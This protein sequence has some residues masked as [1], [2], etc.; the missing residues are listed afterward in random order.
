MSTH[1]AAISRLVPYDA[2]LSIFPV[3]HPQRVTLQ[4]SEGVII[5]PQAVKTT[6]LAFQNRLLQSSGVRFSAISQPTQLTKNRVSFFAQTPYGLMEM[7]VE[8]RQEFRF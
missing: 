8:P 3:I 7:W 5:F 6:T 2:Q 4:E 1:L